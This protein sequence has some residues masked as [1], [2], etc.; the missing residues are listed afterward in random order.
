MH[1][2][3]C[4]DGVINQVSHLVAHRHHHQPAM[5]QRR[6]IGRPPNRAIR[7]VR[8]VDGNDDPIAD[9]EGIQ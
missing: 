3:R 6:L 1:E 7:V 4:S 9:L 2:P 5:L 8:S